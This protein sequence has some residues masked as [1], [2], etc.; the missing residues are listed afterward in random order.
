MTSLNCTKYGLIRI[1]KPDQEIEGV[2]PFKSKIGLN[3]F[4]AKVARCY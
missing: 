4:G 1:K 2:E 3:T